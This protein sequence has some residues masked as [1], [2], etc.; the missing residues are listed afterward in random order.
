MDDD[1]DNNN[2]PSNDIGDTFILGFNKRVKKKRTRKIL[3]EKNKI[4]TI[5]I[6][7]VFI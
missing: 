3:I 5:I 2:I 4:R 6:K 7:Y 1:D